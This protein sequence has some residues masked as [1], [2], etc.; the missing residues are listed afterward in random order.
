MEARQGRSWPDRRAR[1]A[2]EPAAA[3][4]K[5]LGGSPRGNGW[6]EAWPPLLSLMPAPA[7]SAFGAVPE[8]APSRKEELAVRGDAVRET[9]VQLYTRFVGSTSPP[10]SEQEQRRIWGH[11]RGEGETHTHTI[12]Q[13]LSW[14][15]CLGEGFPPAAPQFLCS[16]G[17]FLTCASER[18][19]L[20]PSLR[21]SFACPPAPPP[22]PAQGLTLVA[23]FLYGSQ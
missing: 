15:L 2:C 14:V 5:A 23:L 4:K 3:E 12:K 9:E 16:G 11:K 10:P 7:R 13:C 19:F 18:T 6:G 20:G 17:S 1:H 8:L 21:G 22:R